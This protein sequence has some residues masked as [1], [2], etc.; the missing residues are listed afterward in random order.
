[1]KPTT[2]NIEKSHVSKFGTA[3]PST[4]ND[5]PTG[6]FLTDGTQAVLL[7]YGKK[8]CPPKRPLRAPHFDDPPVN[9]SLRT[10]C[11]TVARCGS[12][13]RMKCNAAMQRRLPRAMG[14]C[15]RFCLGRYNPAPWVCV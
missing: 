12:F 11:T 4:H 5:R 15:D 8:G 6:E 14:G 3:C 7:E 1:M 10:P 2:W 13:L 9:R